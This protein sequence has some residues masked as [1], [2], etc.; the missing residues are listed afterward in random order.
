[1]GTGGL[2]SGLD[3]DESGELGDLDELDD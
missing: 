2:G 3:V 1:V